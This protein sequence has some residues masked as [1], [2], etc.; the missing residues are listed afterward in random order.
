MRQALEN[1]LGSVYLLALDGLMVRKT[2]STK[3]KYMV[4]GLELAVGGS[5]RRGKEGEDVSG[6]G[7]WVFSMAV[8]RTQIKVTIPHFVKGLI[9]T[10]EA[11]PTLGT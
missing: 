5:K 11:G 10:T 1:H 2:R 8:L 4:P 9:I 3:G 7:R 6:W